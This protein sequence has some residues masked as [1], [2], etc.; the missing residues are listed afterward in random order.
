MGLL[1]PLISGMGPFL[2]WPIEI[3]FPFPYIAE[4]IF[5]GIIV[6]LILQVKNK[7]VQEKLVIFSALFFSLSESVLYIFNIFAVGNIGIFFLRLAMT[8]SLHLLSFVIIYFVSRKNIKMLPLG[9]LIAGVLH[10][11]YNYL[12]A[13]FF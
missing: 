4:E 2:L 13:L 6:Y 8:I 7:R 11:F 12:I 1:T 5:K 10:Y 3:I 9:I